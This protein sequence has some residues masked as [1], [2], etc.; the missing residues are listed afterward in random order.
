MFSYIFLLFTILPIAYAFKPFDNLKTLIHNDNLY[1]PTDFDPF[2]FQEKLP[3]T[4]KFLKEAELKHCR[5]G[6]ISS[7]VIPLSEM[8][9]NR[10][11]IHEF[12]MLPDNYK[13]L[14]VT[15]LASAEFQFMLNGWENPMKEPFQLKKSYTEGDL[16][17]KLNTNNSI[18][19]RNKEL[20]NGRMAMIMSFY[21]IVY[22][23]LTGNKIF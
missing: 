16:G 3:V 6:M 13:L 5:W 4:S 8:D 1:T 12:D 10:P 23:Q 17:F 18:Y 2:G 19:T 20:F 22:E 9:S 11:A 21:Y 14:I 7:A 15:F